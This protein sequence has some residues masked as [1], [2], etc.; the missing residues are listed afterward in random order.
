MI[1]AWAPQK[2]LPNADKAFSPP[3]HLSHKLIL[4]FSS[5]LFLTSIVYL[6]SHSNASAL[7]VNHDL[8]SDRTI[9]ITQSTEFGK[10]EYFAIFTAQCTIVQ[11]AV[12]RL[13]VVRLCV[14]PS[15]RLWRWCIR[16]TC[17]KSWKLIARTISPT[18]S[19]CV[20]QRPSTYS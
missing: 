3:F 19:L 9:T 4:L 11:S 6:I 15:V 16:T 14:R 2:N 17:W 5:S 8:I 10:W 7:T 12:W 13:Y 1:H 18:P 20:A